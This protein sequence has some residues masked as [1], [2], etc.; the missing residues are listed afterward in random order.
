MRTSKNLKR[1]LLL[2]TMVMTTSALWSQSCPDNS[3]RSFVIDSVN[4]TSKTVYYSIHSDSAV[5]VTLYGSLFNEPKYYE[6]SSNSTVSDSV[7][8]ENES[9]IFYFYINYT[10]QNGCYAYYSKTLDLGCN[11]Y[12]YQNNEVACGFDFG[13]TIELKF[14]SYPDSVTVVLEDKLGS[15]RIDSFQFSGTKDTSYSFSNVGFD[16]LRV[17][18][19]KEFCE[20]TEY[21]PIVISGNCSNFGCDASIDIDT[22]GNNRYKFTTVHPNANFYSWN[23]Y[24][25]YGTQKIDTTSNTLEFTLLNNTLYSAQVWAIDTYNFCFTNATTQLATNPCY[26]ELNVS[27]NDTIVHFYVTVADTTN[28]TLIL[29]YGD[30]DIDTV[31]Y[32]TYFLHNYPRRDTTYKAVLTI[33]T[34]NEVCNVISRDVET[35]D[36]LTTFSWYPS[37]DPNQPLTVNLYLYAE[38]SPNNGPVHHKRYVLDFGD[39][40]QYENAI[41]SS[42]SHT[43]PKAGVYKVTLITEFYGSDSSL[44]CN[45]T[46]TDRVIV[47]SNPLVAAFSFDTAAN[48][49]ILFFDNSIGSIISYQWDFGDGST[50]SVKDP[51]HQYNSDGIYTVCLS[52][53]D[54]WGNTHTT[55]KDISIGNPSCIIKANF[56]A[57]KNISNPLEITFTNLSNAGDKFYWDFGDGNVST[58]KSPTH[59]YDKLGKYKVTLTV[60]NS[61]GSCNSSYAQVITAGNLDCSAQFNVF[62]NSSTG[63]V[64]VTNTSLSAN[65]GE[66]VYFWNFGDGTY[67][68]NTNPSTKTYP[69]DG[70]YRISLIVY[71]PNT[72]CY[73]YAEKYVYISRPC[74]AL[75]NYYVD[76]ATHTVHLQNLSQNADQYHW[77]FSD[78]GY[79]SN[80]H[81]SYSFSAP[82]IY[83]ISLSIS[84][85]SGCVD[86]HEE[87]VTVGQS[88]DCEAIFTYRVAPGNQVYFYDLSNGD[89]VKYLWNFGNGATSDQ[90]NPNVIY[91]KPGV[92]NVCLTVVNAAGISN[93]TCEKVAI[94]DACVADYDFMIETGRKVRFVESS[95]G[96]PTSYQ[97]NFGDNG[98]ASGRKV[99]HTYAANGYYL[100]NLNISNSSTCRSAAYK[101]INVGMPGTIKAA[102]VALSNKSPNKAGGYPVDFIGAGLGD[103]VRIKW[104]FGDGTEDTTTTTPTHVYA[105]PGTYT[106]CY[107]ISDPITGASDTA[108]TVVTITGIEDPSMLSSNLQVYPMPFDDW[109]N[110]SL[111]LEKSSNLRISLYDLTGRNLLVSRR[112]IVGPGNAALNLSTSHIKS[113]TYLLHIQIGGYNYTR[114]VVKQ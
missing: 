62:A 4:K 49:N 81:P 92:Y 9:F 46:Y 23:I 60:A 44:L 26:A 12:T 66:T 52:V 15:N 103:D 91:N 84:N 74:K 96:N 94:G 67:S 72:G 34:G 17:T 58:A 13:K 48:N 79:S 111:S 88:S 37:Y 114:L 35:K 5:T 97:W 50:S 87:Y 32:N 38:N 98:Q 27:S 100:T 110:I 14:S 83:K 75:F 28:K 78:G 105:N 41:F 1:L 8:Y 73:D 31:T 43:Y 109:L 82:G 85:A 107:I 64:T 33:K 65:E 45:S 101:L 22:L 99:E 10:Y 70:K 69:K 63:E 56:I 19:I 40:Q 47:G 113:G 11:A 90:P 2:L 95:L 25:P 57:S 29:S 36:C 104:V 21:V 68:S 61:T 20:R 77:F 71:N 76:T 59:T 93:I 112:E 108:C 18:Y 51:I 89:I 80:E 30:G 106:A 24:T 3:T 7:N 53:K 42:I 39:G 6:I 54:S 16:T 102:V 55:C 86:S